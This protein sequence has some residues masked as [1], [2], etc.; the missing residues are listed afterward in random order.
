M[1]DGKQTAKRVNMLFLLIPLLALSGCKDAGSP[2]PVDIKTE[3][4]AK[5]EKQNFERAFDEYS[6]EEKDVVIVHVNKALSF[7]PNDADELEKAAAINDYV[8]QYFVNKSNYG[9]AAKLLKEGYA[10]CGGAAVTMS[11]MLYSIGIKS[12]LAFLIGI[13]NQGAHSLVE[14]YFSNGTRGLYDPTF[15]ILW[16]DHRNDMP[17]SITKLLED[18]RLSNVFLY[19]S[20]NK[21]RDTTEEGIRPSRGF[22]QTYESRKNYR[23]KY[24]DPYLS[25]LKR[26][27]G[28]VSGEQY[29]TY[30]KIPVKPDILYGDKKG[31]VES[32][33]PWTKLAVLQSQEEEYI[34]WAYMVGKTGVYNISH[35]YQLGD[36]HIGRQYILT[37]YYAKASDAILSIQILNGHRVNQDNDSTFYYELDNLYYKKDDYKIEHIGIPF[38]VDSKD[39]KII[40]STEGYLILTAIELKE[41]DAH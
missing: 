20:E 21:K 36:L 34:S 27:G 18:P 14:V 29:K 8:Y 26:S 32:A 2:M 30:V 17:I 12:R 10:I 16:Y 39:V 7:L 13:P 19:K 28:G 3:S 4:N 41:N 37:I 23:E 31:N 25:F 22:L 11:E 38:I 1:S 40:M 6:V 5:V 35:I 15:G 24:Y 9:N 33:F